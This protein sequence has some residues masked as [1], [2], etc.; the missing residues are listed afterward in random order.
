MKRSM[1]HQIQGVLVEAGRTDLAKELVTGE[2]SWL[3]KIVRNPKTGNKVKVKSLP[4][5]EQERYRPKEKKKTEP[6]PNAIKKFMK[7]FRKTDEQIDDRRSAISQ[8]SEWMGEKD[9]E[10]AIDRDVTLKKLEKKKDTTLKQINS[11]GYNYD[12]V[13]DSFRK[14]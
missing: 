1:L 13:S 12:L 2:K 9:I 10:K 4:P 5:K 8:G 6:D 3:D 14:K 11:I 7:T